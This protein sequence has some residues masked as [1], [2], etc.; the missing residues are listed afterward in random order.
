[1]F[2]SFQVEVEMQAQID[3]FELLMGKKPFHVD[4]HQHV[5]LLPGNKDKEGVA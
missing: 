1:L 4:G 3:R 5:H 2:I